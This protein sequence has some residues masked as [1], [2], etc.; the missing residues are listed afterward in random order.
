M[1][2]NFKGVWIPAQIWLSDNLS[3][4]EKCL[5]AEIDSFSTNE[6]PCYASNDHFAKFLGVGTATVTRAL[7]K[8]EKEGFI[9][10][11]LTKDR[12]KQGKIS[13][14]RLIKMINGTA[15]Q[16]DP[17]TA[18]QNDEYTNTGTTNTYTHTR[19]NLSKEQELTLVSLAKQLK[20]TVEKTT[21]P[22]NYQ[23]S[24]E[25][26]ASM[27]LRGIP[28]KVI[29]NPDVLRKFICHYQS[30]GLTSAKWD[31]AFEKW[32]LNEKNRRSSSK[33][34]SGNPKLDLSDPNK[35]PF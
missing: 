15:N 11:F 10:V 19:E 17:S 32:C 28:G 12:D 30:S 33:S 9:T 14:I 7:K 21:I 6:K 27:R 23:P 22:D 29:S 31:A 1:H 5:L 2:R 16:N 20:P 26:I 18:N 4:V 24:N 34:S 35:D 3:L 25:C 13:T 8:L